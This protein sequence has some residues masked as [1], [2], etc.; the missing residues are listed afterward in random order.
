MNSIVKKERTVE[1]VLVQNFVVHDILRIVRTI[2]A[3]NNNREEENQLKNRRVFFRLLA[4]LAIALNIAIKKNCG[5][6]S[7]LL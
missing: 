3:L 1:T 5:N 6:S 4:V 7:R 2:S